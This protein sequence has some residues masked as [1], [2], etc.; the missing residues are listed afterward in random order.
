MKRSSRAVWARRVEAWQ[1]SGLTAKAYAQRIRVNPRTL[2][3]WK[4]ELGRTARVESDHERSST[5]P[6]SLECHDGGFSFVEVITGA[7][8]AVSAEPFELLL[9][10]ERRVRVP[11]RF[12]PQSLR[13]LLSVLEATS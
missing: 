2:T 9:G 10:G 12:D 11:S 13:L 6:S 3:Y 4:W 1:K 7:A 5:V 8:E